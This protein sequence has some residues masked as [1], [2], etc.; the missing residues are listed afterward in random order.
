MQ[1][2]VFVF[3]WAFP[4]HNQDPVM[5]STGIESSGMQ[6]LHFLSV[7]RLWISTSD[8][9][10]L[11]E[12]VRGVEDR[13]CISCTRSSFPQK[14]IQ[15]LGL[16]LLSIWICL[17]SFTQE[18]NLSHAWQDEV[19]SNLSSNLITGIVN[20]HTDFGF[21]IEVDAGEVVVPLLPLLNLL[22]GRLDA[23]QLTLL[24][25]L[26]CLEICIASTAFITPALSHESTVCI[27]GD[28]E[29]LLEFADFHFSSREEVSYL[30]ADYIAGIGYHLKTLIVAVNVDFV[31]LAF[32]LGLCEISS[33]SG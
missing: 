10:L 4:F 11:K 18:S 32:G 24:E 16:D 17:R 9:H 8:S 33:D 25:E 28:T 27:G 3:V 12:Y 2:T 26:V 29:G 13:A 7:L 1:L 20:R 30:S 21:A 5:S 22:L 14:V 31:S 23:L 19:C 15:N 6:L